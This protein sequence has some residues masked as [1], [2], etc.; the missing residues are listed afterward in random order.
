MTKD[1][2]ET[3]PAP[4]LSVSCDGDLVI[5]TWSEQAI[6][7]KG[8]KYSVEEKGNL[9][10][11]SGK[12]D[13]QLNIPSDT[14]LHVSDVAGD[15]VVK[16]NNGDAAIEIV[17]GDMVLRGLESA[18]VGTV[19]GDVSVRHLT[20]PANLETV[21]GDLAAAHVQELKI[22]EAKGDAS[23]RYATGSVMVDMVSGDIDLRAIDGPVTVIAGQ[24]DANLSGLKGVVNL[25]EIKGD[26]RLKGG[27]S[28]G[29]HILHA[30]RDIVVR[31]PAETP[32]NLIANAPVVANRATF[33]EFEQK[34]DAWIGRIGDG[35]TNVELTA[36]RQIQLKDA[37]AFDPRWETFDESSEDFDFAFDFG[38]LGERISAQ[39][40]EKV[41][42]F[43]RNM[44]QQFGPDFG[45]EI[46]VKLAQK[47]EKAA[48][49]AEKAAERAA[50][51]AE[52]AAER[53]RAQSERANNRWQDYAAPAPT[54]PSP[55]KAA[56]PDEQ[57]KILRMVEK[58]TISPEEASMLL[59]ALES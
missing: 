24:R 10:T 4:A 55:P 17:H 33:D 1:K 3:G 31:W 28:T 53:G 49:R 36:G 46:G 13:L 40:N 11:L 30:Q 29:N 37:E 8:D 39:I 19:H 21:H 56:S 35:K 23:V 54:A 44:E 43:T 38:N 12:G 22:G 41:E 51:R 14:A 26:I 16:V 48:M 20:G 50:Q 5:K 57:L 18:K 2:I 9:W 59:E 32:I 45:H 6:S 34:G 52:A 15:L 7:V 58:G 27:L 42:M 25:P 47:A